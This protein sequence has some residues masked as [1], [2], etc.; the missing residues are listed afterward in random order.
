VLSRRSGKALSLAARLASALSGFCY[1]IAAKAVALNAG[2]Y[3]A[4]ARL[5]APRHPTRSA[6]GETRLLL[7]QKFP[8][9]LRHVIDVHLEVQVR[10]GRSSGRSHLRLFSDTL[11]DFSHCSHDLAGVRVHGHEDHV[12]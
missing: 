2:S 10:A 3:P 11:D 6:S 12:P 1:R 9:I 7:R 4:C 8:R 5:A